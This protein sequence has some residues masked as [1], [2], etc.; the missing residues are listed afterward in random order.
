MKS[1]LSK[2]AS[3]PKSPKEN[4]GTEAD[5]FHLSAEDQEKVESER[6]FHEIFSRESRALHRFFD[7]EIPIPPLPKEATTERILEWRRLGFE[8][9]YLPPVSMVE[10]KRDADGV[11]TDVQPK[12][13]P[14]WRIKP[15]NLF[16]DWIRDEKISPEAANLFGSWM[17]VES[18]P[19]PNYDNGDQMFPNDFLAPILI[20]LR[21]KNIINRISITGKVFFAGSRFG[22]SVND[23][24][25]TQVRESLNKAMKIPEA[26]F[27]LL[28]AI[29]F[30][31]LGNLYYPE[32]GNTNTS[33]QFE[34][35]FET[36]E[37]L[38]GGG[39]NFGGLSY[40]FAAPLSQGDRT[41]GFRVIARFPPN[42]EEAHKK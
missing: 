36:R 34:D 13:F 3:K 41:V 35:R 42:Q 39:S 17:L 38:C 4:F 27:S 33:E 14:G 15:W 29:E 25:K 19:T 26:S 30:N 20:E 18:Q 23:L 40:V 12:N 31:V 24:D 9:H 28:R 21:Q 22:L 5:D 11:I 6:I 8:L 32:W 1:V 2:G 10:I 37:R 16:F 7:K